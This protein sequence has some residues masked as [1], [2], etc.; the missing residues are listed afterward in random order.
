M[1][2]TYGP[3]TTRVLGMVGEDSGEIIII[4]PSYIEGRIEFSDANGPNGP[5][6]VLSDGVTFSPALGDG[7]YEVVAH[8]REVIIGGRSIGTQIAKVEIVFLEADGAS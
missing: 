4:D 3:A 7:S 8:E 1:A 6:R 5:F 2:M